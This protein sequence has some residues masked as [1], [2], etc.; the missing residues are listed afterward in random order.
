MAETIIVYLWVS[1][2]ATNP[3][4]TNAKPLPRESNKKRPPAWVWL[5]EKSCSRLI[6]KGAD[7][8]LAKK[9]KKKTLVKRIK[10]SETPDTLGKELRGAAM[11]SQLRLLK[12]K[13]KQRKN[14]TTFHLES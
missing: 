1:L 5:K 4:I 13:S 3:D 6:K 14:R 9:L 11:N 7:I 10:E 12:K 8:N 2:C